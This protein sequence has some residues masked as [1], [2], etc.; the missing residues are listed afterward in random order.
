MRLLRRTL[1][2]GLA[3]LASG[4][5]GASHAD[6]AAP[7]AVIAPSGASVAMTAAEL[8]SLPAVQVTVSFQTEHGPRHYSFDG[9]LLW[10]VLD[11]AHAIDPAKPRQAVRQTVLVTGSDGYT[12]ALALGEIAPQFEGKQVIL[13]EKMDGHD[14]GP[15]HLR[16]VVPGD[17]FGG[18]SVRDVVRIAVMQPPAMHAENTPSDGR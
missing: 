1:L 8:A 12:A 13:A 9:P 3:L 5:V 11:H 2:A 10:T 4:A 6:P 18:R 7:V 15:D 16:I 17:R 14:L